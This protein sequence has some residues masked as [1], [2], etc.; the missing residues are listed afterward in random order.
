MQLIILNNQG[1][2]NSALVSIV[3]NY[4]V[5]IQL[6]LQV[7]AFAARDIARGFLGHLGNMIAILKYFVLNA[8]YITFQTLEF[9]GFLKFSIFYIEQFKGFISLFQGVL[10]AVGPPNLVRNCLPNTSLH[11]EFEFS[12]LSCLKF[13][14]F[15]AISILAIGFSPFNYS[16]IITIIQNP[17][18][19]NAN[20]V[21]T[22]LIDRTQHYS[23]RT[24]EVTAGVTSNF[25]IQ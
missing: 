11:C 20:Q 9:I 25:P 5:I 13:R 18:M 23:D 19:L 12:M 21:Q 7:Q 2:Y 8:F 6:D 22:Q 15:D 4:N 10:P 3:E 1:D 17:R 14:F 24:L 16:I